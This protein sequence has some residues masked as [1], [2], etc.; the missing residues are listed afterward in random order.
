MPTLTITKKA[1]WRNLLS[2]QNEA[3]LLVTMRSKELWLVQKNHVTGKPYSPLLVE[4]TYLQRNQNWTAKSRNLKENAGKIKS[5]FVI[6]QPCEPRSS[7]VA[8][9]IAGVGQMPSELVVAV[10]LEV[11]WFEFW[12]KGALVTVEIIVFCDWWFLNQFDAVSETHFGCNTVVRELLLAILCSLLCS[13][14]DLNIRIGKQGYVF[15][16]TYFKK[17]CFDVSLLTPISVSSLFLRLW[18]VDFL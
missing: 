5:V 13:E 6:K 3:I 8:L 10:H 18:K 14:T 2:I 1:I 11:T 9:H 4:W 7:D 15:I 12:K 17:W 16:L